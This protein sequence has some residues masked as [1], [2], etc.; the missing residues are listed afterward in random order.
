M[1][2]NNIKACISLIYC[3]RVCVLRKSSIGIN[4]K[5]RSVFRPTELF[6]TCGIALIKQNVQQVKLCVT[7]PHF[8]SHV[9]SSWSLRLQRSLIHSPNFPGSLHHMSDNPVRFLVTHSDTGPSTLLRPLSVL[10]AFP[11]STRDLWLHP[12]KCNQ[13][14]R[15]CRWFSV[16][17]S[18][19]GLDRG[20][21]SGHNDS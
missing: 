4:S 18:V 3:T 10:R 7:L 6:A 11:E 2:S 14:P 5:F 13:P 16:I 20:A 17:L 19:T 21:L 15:L 9:F 8:L 12:A 1:I